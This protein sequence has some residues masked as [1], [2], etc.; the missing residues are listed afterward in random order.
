MNTVLFV[1]AA[2]DSC[3]VGAKHDLRVDN[4][5]IR[6]ASAFDWSNADKI[7]Q[8]VN[9]AGAIPD[10]PILAIRTYEHGG[11]KRREA[12]IL[13]PTAIKLSGDVTVDVKLA[14]TDTYALPDTVQ[15]GT[16]GARGRSADP[17]AVASVA[18]MHKLHVNAGMLDPGLD[19]FTTWLRGAYATFV[20]ADA[21]KLGRH[22]VAALASK[23]EVCGEK[24]PDQILAMLPTVGAE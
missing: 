2:S 20:G 4:D 13:V 17:F 8:T 11:V 21:S 16:V 5:A 24:T 14:K 12:A 6:P 19:A 15:I 10:G 7:G 22:T 3:N 18:P 1:V 23:L 9:I